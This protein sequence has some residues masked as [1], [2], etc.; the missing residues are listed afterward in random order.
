MAALG[1]PTDYSDSLAEDICE[2]L[3][4]GSSLRAVCR[5]ES[6]PSISTVM[7]WI[8]DNQ[9]FREQYATSTEERVVGMFEDM[10]DISDDVPEEPAAIAKAKLRVDTRKWAL[11]RMNPK[12]YG[13]KVTNEVV[14]ADGGPIQQSHSLDTSSLTDD[15]LRAL[16]SIKV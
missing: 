4:N 7:R 9:R 5:S 15:Q 2:K 3:V 11:A 14:G 8:A 16:A 6:M 1:R 12:K 10:F 13:D